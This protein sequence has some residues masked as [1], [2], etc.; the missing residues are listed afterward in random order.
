MPQENVEGSNLVS[1]LKACAVHTVEP[2]VPRAVWA[3]VGH[4][5]RQLDKPVEFLWW[6]AAAQVN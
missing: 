2:E 1:L 4:H 6:V 3:P 5:V